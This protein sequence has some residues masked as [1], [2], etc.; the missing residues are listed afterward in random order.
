MDD[1]KIMGVK[2]SSI[3]TQVKRELTIVFEM[4]DMGPIS[5][6]LGLKVSRDQEKK[7]FKLSQPTYID[8]ILTKFHLDQ[9]KTANTLMKET[10][11]LPNKGKEVI[12][13]EK[14][15]YQ[16]MTSSIIFSMVKIRPNIA[17]AT[18]MISHFAKNL[19]YLYSKAVK[20]IFYYLKATRDVEIMYGGE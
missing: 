16:G 15:C 12:A 1:I 9:V 20:T 4:A 5:F 13:A 11:L 2:D 17:Y 14:K 3:I 8:K 7:T 18:S 10:C 19:S 6:Y